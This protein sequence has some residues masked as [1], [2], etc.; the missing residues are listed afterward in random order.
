MTM[1]GG[2]VRPRVGMVSKVRNVPSLCEKR[3]GFSPDPI[4]QR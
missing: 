2:G 4:P 3:K 1:G